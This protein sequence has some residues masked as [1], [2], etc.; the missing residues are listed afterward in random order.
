M[1]FWL[2]Y[3]RT[4][5]RNHAAFIAFG[6]ANAA[7]LKAGPSVDSAEKFIV[8]LKRIDLSGTGPRFSAAFKLYVDGMDEGISRLKAGKEIGDANDKVKSGYS[9][10]LAISRQSGF[11]W[12]SSFDVPMAVMLA[13]SGSF[14]LG[15]RKQ[16]A[17]ARLER[18]RRGE[19]TEH[20][21]QRRNRD[22]SLAGYTLILAGLG[23]AVSHYLSN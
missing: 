8:A 15:I 22:L 11:E 3:M 7:R 4:L 9:E 2:L 20:L 16:Q 10:L 6:E 12:L 21:A 23:I 17:A 13:L 19:M 5:N 1:A 14:S 18:V